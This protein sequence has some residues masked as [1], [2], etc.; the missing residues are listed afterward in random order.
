MASV[1]VVLTVPAATL[2]ILLVAAVPC[3][4]E[5]APRVESQFT[6]SEVDGVVITADS[7]SPTLA[8]ALG[9]GSSVDTNGKVT[10]PKYKVAGADVTGVDGAIA[11]LDSGVTA[12]T[13]SLADAVKYDDSTH[14]KVTFNKGGSAV[15]LTNVAAGALNGTSTDA[16]NGTQLYTTNQNVAGN[17]TAITNIMNGKAG[18]VQQSAAGANLTVGA[19]TDGAAI[20]MKGTAGNRK[21][22]DVANGIADND[23]ANI[24]QMKSAGFAFDATGA[25]TNKAVTYNAGSIASG[26]PTITLAAGTG[27]SKYFKDGDRTKGKLPVGTVISNVANGIQDTDAASVG[28]VNDIVNASSGNG[29]LQGTLLRGGLLGATSGSGVNTAGL[30]M[31]YKTAAYYSQV[32]GLGDSSGSTPPSDVARA[33]GAGSIA[34]GSNAFT[35]ATAGTAMGVQAYT[36]A[37]DAVALGSGSVANTA[38]TVSVGSDGTG[39]YTAYDASGTAYTIKNQANTRRIVNMAAGTADTDAVNVSQLKGMASA[40][41]GGSTV[42]SD[43]SIKSP[44]Y[45]VGGNTYNTDCAVPDS[46]EPLIASVLV[47]ETAPAA[48]LMSLRLPA[49]PFMSMAAPSVAAPTVRLAPAADCCTRPALP[50]LILVMSV[51]LLATF[52]LVV[53]S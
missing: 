14:G 28:Q 39:S 30:G 24:S 21:L 3:A 11:A 26:T 35:S 4:A 51:V 18:L 19:A 32:A 8:D 48:T 43:G 45:T 6:E 2:V 10:K 22:I 37:S 42:N 17:T 31:S 27:T 29:G 7:A 34:I 52:W 49:V 16:V 25:V 9:G 13:T 5:Y 33:S 46:C 23:V 1:L 12:A 38:N 36:S 53:Y 44:T 20:D 47:V 50:F 41:G 40:L 15:T